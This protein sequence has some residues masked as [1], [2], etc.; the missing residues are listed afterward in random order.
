M[1]RRS[2]LVLLVALV[3][4]LLAQP[5]PQCPPEPLSTGSSLNATIELSGC[6]YL[7]VFDASRIESQIRQ[8][9]LDLAE[10]SVVTLELNSTEFDPVLYLHDSRKRL[11]TRNDNRSPDNSNS[12]IVVN[13]PPGSYLVVAAARAPGT[14]GAFELIS[15]AQAPRSC[16]VQD[17]TLG[18]TTQL[19]FAR[20]SSCRLLDLTSTTSTNQTLVARYRMDVPQRGAVSLTTDQLNPFLSLVSVNDTRRAFSGRG[21]LVASLAADTYQLTLTSTEEGSLSLTGK[22]QDLRPCQVRPL[23][24]NGELITGN[25]GDDD[26]R[27]LDFFVPNSD[28][29]PLHVYA[30]TLTED[31]VVTLAMESGDFDTFLAITNDSNDVIAV[32]DDAAEDV[33]NSRIQIHL[34]RGEF[35]I[36]AT[37]FQV[38]T[39]GYT[40]Q[41]AAEPV[42]DCAPPAFTLNTTIEG[43]FPDD[44]CRILDLLPFSTNSAPTRPFRFSVPERS[45][46]KLDLNVSP[47]RGSMHLIS[48]S[49]VTVGL[50]NTD[51]NG[52]AGLETTIPAGEYTL[53]AASPTTPPPSFALRGSLRQQPDCAVTDLT[54]GN[55]VTRT[56]E[57]ADC[58]Y[59]EIAPFGTAG[60]RSHRYRFVLDA[61]SRIVFEMKSEEIEPVVVLMNDDER[62]LAIGAAETPATLRLQGTIPAGTYRAILTATS[63]ALG[64]Y[65]ASLTAEPVAETMAAPAATHPPVIT[66]ESIN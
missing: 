45:V 26:C 11:L 28:A 27:V 39:G 43:E 56:L 2:G 51:A 65:T 17:F 1:I 9:T 5:A 53:A 25:L 48:Q 46:G 47:G 66:V 61:P 7:D 18:E 40:L 54:P 12:Q 6:R 58:R 33:S 10:R 31:A 50:R 59:F 52:N 16:P 35:K 3:P 34:P 8:Y 32:N 22:I 60:T 41:A 29:A 64:T 63:G 23:E 36:L 57:A 62:V 38:A 37:A 20:T 49:G 24:A 4:T 15:A 14:G 30:I 55:P 44:G 13:L 21:Q 19:A 42:R